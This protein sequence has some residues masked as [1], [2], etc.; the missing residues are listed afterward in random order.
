[1]AALQSKRVDFEKKQLQE[2]VSF[3]MLS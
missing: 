3:Q 2:H 1:L